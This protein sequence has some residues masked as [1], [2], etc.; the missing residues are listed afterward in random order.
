MT[1][2]KFD[3]PLTDKD[4]QDTDK[5]LIGETLPSPSQIRSILINDTGSAGLSPIPARED[6]L[7][8]ID[9][10]GYLTEADFPGGNTGIPTPTNLSNYY[11]KDEVNE[12]LLLFCTLC[13]KE[14]GEDPVCWYEWRVEQYDPVLDRWV[15]VLDMDGSVIAGFLELITDPIPY[16]L[17]T[18]PDGYAY[19]VALR[20]ICNAIPD[21]W[22]L[23]DPFFPD[24]DWKLTCSEEVSPSFT[25]AI[26]TDAIYAIPRVCTESGSTVIRDNVSGAILTQGPAFLAAINDSDDEWGLSS[27]LNVGLFAQEKAFAWLPSIAALN[28]STD[29]SF[30]FSFKFPVLL[31]SQVTTILTIGNRIRFLVRIVNGKVQPY[32]TIQK[33][34]GGVMTL[35]DTNTYALGEYVE[36]SL[37]ITQ[38]GTF[39]FGVNYAIVDTNT[40]EETASLAAN[41]GFIRINGANSTVIR[42]IFGWDSA[43]NIPSLDPVISIIEFLG[44]GDAATSSGGDVT[45]AYPS[46]YTPTDGDMA[47]LVIHFS[48]TSATETDFADVSI[49]HTYTLIHAEDWGSGYGA[50]WYRRRLDGVT[51]LAD[52]TINWPYTSVTSTMFAQVSIFRGVDNVTPVDGTVESSS[53]GA[54]GVTRAV[55]PA[56]FTAGAVLFT[57]TTKI[58]GSLTGSGILAN[59]NERRGFDAFEYGTGQQFGPTNRRVNTVTAWKVSPY[60]RAWESIQWSTINT[61]LSFRNVAFALRPSKGAFVEPALGISVVGTPETTRLSPGAIF[62]FPSEMQEGDVAIIM[63]GG[64]WA[65]TATT[66]QDPHYDGF[67]RI[68]QGGGSLPYYVAWRRIDGTEPATFEWT[69][70]GSTSGTLIVY[71]GVAATD[72]IGV[73]AS[74]WQ[75]ARANQIGDLPFGP[76]DIPAPVDLMTSSAGY[77]VLNYINVYRGATL[78]SLTEVTNFKG[79]NI[80]DSHRA[81]RFI[82]EVVEYAASSNPIPTVEMNIVSQSSIL[83]RNLMVVVRASGVAPPDPL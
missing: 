65:A 29:C 28:N 83:K 69:L 49:N 30:H 62:T 37:S 2:D 40:D 45:A 72:P 68:F 77:R 34:G 75:S 5:H 57:N 59:F 71:R 18:L 74:D 38:G 9:L 66:A 53:S 17:D 60:V 82:T 52:A 67:T 42:K 20:E 44:H 16:D 21:D 26:Y 15:G 56:S 11:T 32:V 73:S 41:D 46:G 6:H 31:P 25:S 81:T 8:D 79:Y 36:V 70:T 13:A 47:L 35:E 27:K 39:D 14:W 19:R 64:Y 1:S 22:V 58:F 33:V 50:R 76:A 7:H 55:L 12:L 51:D 63:A 10:T 48:A 3:K 24:T 4:H 78:S 23:T 80:L 43:I 61:S 54:S